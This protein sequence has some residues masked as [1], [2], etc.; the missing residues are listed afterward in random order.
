MHF[1]TFIKE[2]AP[3]HPLIHDALTQAQEAV[4][5]AEAFAQKIQAICSEIDKNDQ[6]AQ[7]TQMA[8]FLTNLGNNAAIQ[9]LEILN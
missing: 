3:L 2:N 4:F 7:A 6:K 1:Q 5:S 9:D 8:G